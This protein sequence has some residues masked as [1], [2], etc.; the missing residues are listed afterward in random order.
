MARKKKNV[1]SD[2]RVIAEGCGLIVGILLAGLAFLALGS[3]PDDIYRWIH[4]HGYRQTELILDERSPT[5]RSRSIGV[6]IAATGERV[7]LKTHNFEIPIRTGKRTVLY[8]PAAYMK[9]GGLVVFDERVQVFANPHSFLEATI[10]LWTGLV[11]AAL[12][13]FLV[14]GRR[15]E[16]S[17]R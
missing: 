5:S 6:T 11:L 12:S 9:S 17:R 1:P 13:W 7:F 4:R 2:A 8:N 10:F 3:V 16:T 14:R 15:R